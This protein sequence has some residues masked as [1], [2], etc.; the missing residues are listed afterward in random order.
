MNSHPKSM[1]NELNNKETSN[2]SIINTNYLVRLNMFLTV[3]FIL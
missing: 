2:N 1:A 3:K